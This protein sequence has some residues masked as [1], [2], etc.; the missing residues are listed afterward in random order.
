MNATPRR[1]KVVRDVSFLPCPEGMDHPHR[2]A[3][4]SAAG[5]DRAEPV[6]PLPDPPPR[7]PSAT[8][9]ER[10]TRVNRR[11]ELQCM[12]WE[13]LSL[14]EGR[15]RLRGSHRARRPSGYNL[16]H[17]QSNNHFPSL[18]LRSLFDPR[19]LDAS[20]GGGRRGEFTL[21]PPDRPWP[22]RWCPGRMR[23]SAAGWRRVPSPDQTTPGGRR[24]CPDW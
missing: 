14:S 22:T 6:P 9:L 1:L 11:R 15:C 17:L 19:S 23:G 10:G 5:P 2:A 24:P 7:P 13:G 12:S 16:L 3:S 20:R 21:L 4:Q 8:H 18:T